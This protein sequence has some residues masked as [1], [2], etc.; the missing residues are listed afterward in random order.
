MFIGGAVSLAHT[1][2]SS[3]F[4]PHPHAEQIFYLRSFFAA[5]AIGMD[6]GMGMVA[7]DRWQMGADAVSLKQA[8]NP[9][10]PP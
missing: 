10:L 3:L 5:G 1:E 6:M 7:D 4:R 9:Q 2:G 8:H